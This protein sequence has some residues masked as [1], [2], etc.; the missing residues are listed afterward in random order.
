[1]GWLE[2]GVV[3]KE[4]VRLSLSLTAAAVAAVGPVTR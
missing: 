3:M 2:L 4:E 1:M